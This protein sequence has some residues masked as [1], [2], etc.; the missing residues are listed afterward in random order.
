MSLNWVC[1]MMELPDP[2][3]LP[4]VVAFDTESTGLTR[5]DRA[6]GISAA[7]GVSAPQGGYWDLRQAPQ[8]LEWLGDVSRRPGARMVAHNAAFDRKMLAGAGLLMDEHVL[9]DTVIR[10]VMIDEGLMSYRLDDLCKKYLKAK[11]DD[12]IYAK[13]A[14]I[15][16]GVA[17]RNVQMRNIAQ[18]PVEVVSPYA[19]Q[20]ALLTLALWQWQEREIARQGIQSIIEFE[21]GVMPT[22]LRAE[23]R[24]IRVDLEMAHA[25]CAELTPEI[26]AIQARIDAMAGRPLNVNSSPQVKALFNPVKVPDGW[27]TDSGHVIGSTESGA[28]SLGAEALRSMAGDERADAILQ[29]RSMIKT[30]DTFLRGHVIGSEYQGRVFPTISQTKSDSGGGTTTGRLAYSAPALQQLPSRGGPAI[31]MVKSLFLPEEGQKWASF[32]MNSFEVRVFAHFADDPAINAAYAADELSDFHQ[33]VADLTGLPRSAKFSGQANAK[34]LSLSLI[35][36]SGNGSIA[37]KMGLPWTWDGFT[38]DDGEEVTY[39]RAG[40]EA[41]SVITTYHE[42]IPG[43]KDFM[44]RAKKVVTARGYLKTRMGRRIRMPDARFAYKQHG[45]LIQATAADISKIAWGIFERE[46]EAVGGHILL[47]VHDSFEL[48]LP[49][50]VNPLALRDRVQ[51]ALR[52][53]CH[54]F[55][56]PLIID[57]S[58]EGPNYFEATKK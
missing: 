55:K 10:A 53:E 4:L 22:L 28:P 1:S 47:S 30:R 56:I 35:F 2:A 36:G 48:S 57:F 45:L 6:F 13:L 16:G 18:A 19:L 3:R 27:M 52:A 37:A 39:R 41:M 26:A 25:A 20:D 42:R 11:K 8:A 43:V 38:A 34:Q 12:T 32:D 51:A 23:Y 15:F 31:R 24:G 49:I 58:G 14:A 5:R 9:D 50:D 33:V 21:R 7:W 29:I 44:Q 17:T 40:K 46:A 54:W